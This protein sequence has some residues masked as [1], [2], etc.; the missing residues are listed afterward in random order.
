MP[1]AKEE[2]LRA[3]DGP[4]EATVTIAG[5]GGRLIADTR[6]GTL[7]RSA[8]Q[9]LVVEGFFPDTDLSAPLQQDRRPGLTE[10]GLPYEQDPAITRQLAAFWRRTR[11]YLQEQTGRSNPRP[12]YLLFN[13]G[14]F[15]SAPLRARTKQIVGRWFAPDEGP[16]WT[17]TELRNDRLD[18]AVATGAAYYGLVRRGEGT[19][20]GSGSPRAYYVGLETG[21]DEDGQPAICLVPRGA[22]E[23]FEGHLR[24]MEFEA[25]A[26]QPVTFHLFSSTTRSGDAPGDVVRLQ[27]AD[28]ATALPPIRTVLEFGKRYARAVPVQLAVRL[29]EVGTLQLWCDSVYTDHRW[30]LQF[31]V[32]HE[33]EAE[34]SDPEAMIDAEQVEKAL[35]AIRGTFEGHRNTDAPEALWDQLEAIFDAPRDHWPLPLLRKCADTLLDAPRDQSLHHEVCWYNLLGYC[36]RPGYG[37]AVDDWRMQQA[38]ILKI[39]GLAFA[40][41]EDNRMAWWRFWRRVAGGLPGNKQEQFYYE[42]RPFIQLDVRTRKDHAIYSRRAKTREKSEAWQTLATFERAKPAIKT[43]LAELLLEKFEQSGPRPGELWALSRLGTR[44]PVYGPLDKLVDAASVATWLETLLDMDLDAT[45][46]AAYALAHLARPSGDRDLDVP[47]ALRERVSDW[48]DRMDNP[49]PYRALLN[50][51]E[52]A[53]DHPGQDWFIV[54]PLPTDAAAVLDPQGITVATT[55]E[56]AAN[57]E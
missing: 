39:K 23:G 33:P 47:A 30:R 3:D 51:T 17:P 57:P 56:A 44:H 25:L 21:D 26:N 19:R 45:E 27:D 6:S 1:P 10:L 24:D 29:T 54:E 53:P 2:L 31:D 20:V 5:Q 18:L 14:V 34:A 4:D 13:G 35:A 49:V 55:E 48:L 16:D 22:P 37:D 40:R 50:S 12:D 43:E 46:D 38:W 15:N 11:P 32:R 7:E 9:N 8:V 41:R 36:L 28:E 42:A 52:S